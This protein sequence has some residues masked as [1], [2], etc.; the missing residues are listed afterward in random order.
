MKKKSVSCPVETTLALISGRWK[1]LV[2]YHLLGGVKRFG[3]LH[4]DLPGISHRTL[5]KQLREMEADCLLRRKVYA[6]VPPKVEYSL[7]PLGDS[8][9]PVLTAMGAWGDAYGRQAVKER[10]TRP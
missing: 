4:R 10:M 7:T 1:V 5:T 6:E 8:L 2:I 3:E 9:R